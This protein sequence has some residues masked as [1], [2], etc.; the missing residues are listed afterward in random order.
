MNPPLISIIIPVYN[1]EKYLHQCLDSV[2][3]QTYTNWECLL[4]DDGSK[5]SSGVI[6]DEYAAKDSRFRVFHKENGGVS[7]A[8]NDGIDKS[9][10]YYLFFLDADD[11][12]TEDCF[13]RID[14]KPHADVIFTGH[15]RVGDNECVIQ[16]E[17]IAIFNSKNIA[18]YIGDKFIVNSIWYPWGKLIRS[19]I[20]KTNK[21]FFDESLFYSEDF[22]FIMQVLLKSEL[23]MFSPIV[24][25]DYKFVN[26]RE[27]KYSMTSRE[28]DIHYTIVNNTLSKLSEHT[29]NPLSNI[30]SNVNNRLIDKGLWKLSHIHHF[31][32]FAEE[33]INFY[34]IV[35]LQNKGKEY[36]DKRGRRYFYI[37]KYGRYLMPLVYLFRKE[38]K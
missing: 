17:R 19:S 11:S 4:I 18:H 32:E 38:L 24:T 3:A 28:Y 33:F 22:E 34:K 15:N 13:N 6:C 12:L 27:G 8:R 20:V 16:Y 36:L 26:D 29:E 30:K 10:G 9:N 23:V 2:V 35:Y 25:I 1:A 21:L 5:D 7:S 37:F 31:L 14:V